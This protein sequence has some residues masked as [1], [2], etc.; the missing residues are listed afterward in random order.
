MLS[1]RSVGWHLTTMGK[2]HLNSRTDMSNASSSRKRETMEEESEQ[3]FKGDPWMAQRLRNGVVFLQ[4]HDGKFIVV[5]RGLLMVTSEAPRIFSWS[6]DK[7]FKRCKPLMMLA[8]P[9]A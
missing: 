1:Q 9:F 2:S 7:T 4:E 5:K 8:A 3:M 6:F